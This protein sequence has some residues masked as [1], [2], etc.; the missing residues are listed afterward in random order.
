MALPPKFSG[1]LLASAS[2]TEAK[3]T[4][5]LYLDYVCPFSAK[6]FK[7]FYKEVVPLIEKKYTNPGVRVIFRQQIQPWHP[8]STLVHEAG[9]AVLKTSPKSF[10]T[11]SEKLFQQQNDYFDV[12][13]VNETRNNTYK[14]LAKLA[15]SI[16]GIE[17]K[18]VLDLLLVSDKRAEDGSLNIGNQVT[19]D[20]KF[21]VKANRLTGVHVTPTVLFNGVEER[22]ISS[23][24]TVEQ[25]EEW[26][27]KNAT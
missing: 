27:Q 4:I 17:E 10:W 15:G 9:A 23:G 11:F 2:H 12:N 3:H 21:M 16:D 13:V 6:I 18:T 20:V 14:R 26:L 1:Q 8:S 5:E 24:W 7:T 22:S 25:W 19:N